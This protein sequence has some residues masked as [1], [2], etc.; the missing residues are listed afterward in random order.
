MKNVGL[1]NANY[2]I[3]KHLAGGVEMNLNLTVNTVNKRITGVAHITQAI[4]PPMNIIS[5]IQ[6][7]YNYMCTMDSCRIL[8]VA[9][10]VSPFQPLIRDVPLIHKNLTLRI[11]LDE[12]WQSGVANYKY[13]IN[14]VW[15]EVS[16]AKVELI[17]NKDCQ[18]IEKLATM[19]K[20][21][22]NEP[23]A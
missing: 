18:N 22:E 1:F 6:G 20:E 19:V 11:V 3:S 2:R 10:G 13:C 21:K 23:V 4:N 7:D 12:N 15:H 5:E 9:E 14:N 16:Q 17:T 8:I